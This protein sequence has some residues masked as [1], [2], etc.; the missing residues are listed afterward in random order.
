MSTLDT[1][2]LARSLEHAGLSRTAAEA[3]ALAAAK[4]LSGKPPKRRDVAKALADAALP[5]T[6][7]E[8]LGCI[9]HELRLPKAGAIVDTL[10]PA[11]RLEA[12]G[13]ASSQ[14][15]LLL[16]AF[17]Y[18]R[19]PSEPSWAIFSTARTARKLETAGLQPPA[20]EALARFLYSARKGGK[21]DSL[22]VAR[23][24]EARGMAAAQAEAV[25]FGFLRVA[26]RLYAVDTNAMVAAGMRHG[27][28]LTLHSGFFDSTLAGKMMDTLAIADVL[29]AAGTAPSPAAA[30]AEVCFDA[31]TTKSGAV[32]GTH[33]IVAK[34]VDAGLPA[35][36]AEVIASSLRRTTRKRVLRRFGIWL[37]TRTLCR[38]GMTAGQARA[39]A[40]A[41][42]TKTSPPAA[43]S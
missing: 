38:A 31:E 26:N 37:M 33:A 23:A 4:A 10:P 29:Q 27:D 6:T 34:L 8:A 14:T 1:L 22:S 36:H 5:A 16:L 35:R 18:D 19:E 25:A 2:T 20:A 11:R 15:A 42:R 40:I 32:I 43:H 7:V 3:V 24:L 9:F 21:P 12:A 30:I 41:L 39:I 28:A 17:L 13:M